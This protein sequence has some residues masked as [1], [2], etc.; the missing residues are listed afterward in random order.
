MWLTRLAG[1]VVAA[2][3]RLRC[4]AV[5]RRAGEVIAAFHEVPFV[6]ADSVSLDDALNLRFDGWYPRFA[7]V[8]SSELA[9]EVGR[10]WLRRA[11]TQ[12]AERTRTH[13][14]YS[15]RN[16]IW[17]AAMDEPLGVID[18]EQS[19]PDHPWMDL[20]RLWERDFYGRPDLRLAFLQG[21]GLPHDVFRHPDF[22]TLGLQHSV[23]TI[24]WATETRDSEYALVGRAALERWLS[25]A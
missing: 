17:A 1:E 11:P 2:N 18:F 20:T 24:A 3:A 22:R 14:D 4:P 21:Y 8:V 15:D 16:W 7:E 5:F 10:R 19:R 6:D 12:I 13:R 23:A 9:A 25:E